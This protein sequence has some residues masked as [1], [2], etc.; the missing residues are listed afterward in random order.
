MDAIKSFEVW[1]GYQVDVLKIEIVLG[2][3]WD[4]TVFSE[5]CGASGDI[6]V[7]HPT[8]DDLLRIIKGASDGLMKLREYNATKGE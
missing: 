2:V 7:F 1:T 6:T 4:T 5:G 8:E 3:H